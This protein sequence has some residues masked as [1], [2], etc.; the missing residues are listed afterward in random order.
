MR[1]VLIGLTLMLAALPAAADVQAAHEQLFIPGIAAWKTVAGHQ[2]TKAIWVRMIP[3][4]QSADAASDDLLEQ[5]LFFKKGSDPAAFVQDVLRHTA[6][7]C[8]ASDASGPTARTEQGHAVVYAR[9]YCQGSD[10]QDIDIFIK[11]IA[12][13]D[14]LYYVQREFHRP[15]GTPAQ[16]EVRA[17]AAKF[18]DLVRVCPTGTSGDACT[19]AGNTPSQP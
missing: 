8:H 6:G 14:A 18:L 7:T 11:A 3:T 9:L 15:A 13:D 12:G 16:A 4:D 2:N 10:N 17:N 1:G 5:T 19:E